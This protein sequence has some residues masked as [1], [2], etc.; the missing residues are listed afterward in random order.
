MTGQI[1]TLGISVERFFAETVFP[2]F[3]LSIGNKLKPKGGF[4]YLAI[5]ELW[6]AHLLQQVHVDALNELRIMYNN[7][8]HEPRKHVSLDEVIRI[9]GASLLA[10][11]EVVMKNLGFTSSKVFQNSSTFWIGGTD[12]YTQGITEVFVYLPIES[13][14]WQPPPLLLSIFIKGD[15]WDSLKKSLLAVG[16]VWDSESDISHAGL[17]KMMHGEDPLLPI[18]YSGPIQSLL[19]TLHQL[20]SNLV[21]KASHLGEQLKSRV[22]PILSFVIGFDLLRLS[23]DDLQNPNSGLLE[24]KLKTELQNAGI[25][26]GEASLDREVERLVSVF[27]KMPT[28]VVRQVTGPIWMDSASYERLSEIRNIRSTD[29][30]CAL[31]PDLRLM[32]AVVAI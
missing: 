11:G 23:N 6:R 32:I 10:L 29:N 5:E 19:V 16:E 4:F 9:S 31:S 20:R 22:S 26:I 27:S 2:N 24:I 7:Q 3:H 30:S 18:I 13:D 21:R 8:K 25:E 1:A 28:S 17:E 14:D 15:D 12:Y